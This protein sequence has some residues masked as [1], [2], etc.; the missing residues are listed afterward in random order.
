MRMPRALAWACAVLA[1]A[2]AT[3]AA[4]FD[5]ERYVPA[6][7]ADAESPSCHS[8]DRPST[9]VDITLAPLRFAAVA[10]TRVRPLSDTAAHLLDMRQRL[11]GQPTHAVFSQ[12]VLVHIDGQPRWLPIQDQMLA[13]W[14]D[15]TADGAAVTLY[16]VRAGCHS[17]AAPDPAQV[18]FLIN[19]FRVEQPAPP[20]SPQ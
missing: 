6:S 19:E 10:T 1:L 13:A 11:T 5:Y 3:A 14:R 20:E 16:A 9:D 4:A 18:V 8:E 7:L 17:P 2:G 12:E 15:E